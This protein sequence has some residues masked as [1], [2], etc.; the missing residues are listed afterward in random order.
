MKKLTKII[1]LVLLLVTIGLMFAPIATFSDNSANSLAADIEKQEGRVDDAQKKLDRWV[2]EGKKSADDI[3]KQKTKVQKEQ[4]KLDA[5]LAEQEAASDD[6]S[7]GLSYALLPGKLP[8]ELEIDMQVVNQYKVYQANFDAYYICVWTA[9][10]LLVAALV[11]LVLAGDKLVSK[12]YTFSVFAHL[13][14]I[15][16][17]VYCILRLKAFPIA[18]PYGNANLNDLVVWLMI[19]CALVS[20]MLSVRSVYNSKRSM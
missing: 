18:L 11:L 12:L 6:K 4:D 19:G 13:A 17:L 8:A 10:V 1:T 3:E 9:A 14:G 16:M 15:V 5:L 2:S 20:F 7:T